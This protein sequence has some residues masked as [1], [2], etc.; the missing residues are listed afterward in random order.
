MF[1]RIK[2][3]AIISSFFFKVSVCKIMNSIGSDLNLRATT[4]FS[5]HPE[6][7]RMARYF[8]PCIKVWWSNYFFK[9]AHIIHFILFL[10]NCFVCIANDLHWSDFSNPLPNPYS[11]NGSIR[12]KQRDSVRIPSGIHPL[13]PK[14]KELKKKY[15]LIRLRTNWQLSSFFIKIGTKKCLCKSGT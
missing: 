3:I 9:K 12:N 6:S 8:K 10:Y 11:L 4:F 1:V 13:R 15:F 7:G 2:T 5:E 14:K